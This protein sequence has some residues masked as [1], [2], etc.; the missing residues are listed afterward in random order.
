MFLFL[1]KWTEILNSTSFSILKFTEKIITDS[2][3]VQ[4]TSLQN[5]KENYYDKIYITDNYSI[6]KINNIPVYVWEVAT[7]NTNQ[8]VNNSYQD[9]V[10]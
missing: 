3:A 9:D 1:G 6:K 5:L 7:V 8:T 4:R 10:F 2:F